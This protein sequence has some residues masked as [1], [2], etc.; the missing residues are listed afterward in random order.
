MYD[1]GAASERL[2]KTLKNIGNI[3]SNILHREVDVIS[4]AMV[5]LE[6]N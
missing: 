5:T 1:F 3:F 4:L 6:T 2:G